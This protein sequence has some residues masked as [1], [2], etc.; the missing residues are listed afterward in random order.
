M[1]SVTLRYMYELLVAGH[2]REYEHMNKLSYQIPSGISELIVLFYPR[3]DFMDT[4]SIELEKNDVV[5][6]GYFLNIAKQIQKGQVVSVLVGKLQQKLLENPQYNEILSKTVLQYLL[7]SDA[8]YETEY[9]TDDSNNESE[10]DSDDFANLQNANKPKLNTSSA[11][12]ETWKEIFNNQRLETMNDLEKRGIVPTGY[13]E[14][15]KIANFEKKIAK[16]SIIYDL[17][18][19]LQSRPEYSERLAWQLVQNAIA[20]MK[21]TR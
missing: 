20:N 11:I 12:N 2:L 8:E 10:T 9:E 4:L 5:A 3:E 1:S 16:D 18:F 7:L 21:W 14:D 15:V 17:M 6:Q 13:F 19:R